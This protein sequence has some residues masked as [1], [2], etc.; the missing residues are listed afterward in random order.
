MVEVAVEL[1]EGELVE[2]KD[3]LEDKGE[4]VKGKDVKDE[5][6]VP[7]WLQP[8]E[9]RVISVWTYVVDDVEEPPKGRILVTTPK[10]TLGSKGLPLNK[11]E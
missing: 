2:D 7:M 5:L 4:L 11:T 1:V 8:R 6:S 10:E 9:S 3:E